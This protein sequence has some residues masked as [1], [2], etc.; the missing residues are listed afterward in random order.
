MGAQI[1]MDFTT[2]TTHLVVT[3]S[4]SPKYKFVAKNRADVVVVD[5]DWVN[6]MHA[7]W[8]AGEDV[9]VKAMEKKHKL[10]TFFGLKVCVTTFLDGKFA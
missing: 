7:L 3:N 1:G 8:T 9:D 5:L 4:S 2:T 6:E 10:P